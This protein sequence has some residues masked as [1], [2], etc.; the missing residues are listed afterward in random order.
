MDNSLWTLSFL[1]TNRKLI[2]RKRWSSRG[3]RSLV[4]PAM[5]NL[6]SI[7]GV[8]P[9]H[10]RP[11]QLHSD[12]RIRIRI[13]V[14][15]GRPR[16]RDGVRPSGGQGPPRGDRVRRLGTRFT[17]PHHIHPFLVIPLIVPLCVLDGILYPMLR[18]TQRLHHPRELPQC[19]DNTKYTNTVH[20]SDYGIMRRNLKGERE[21]RRKEV[22][23]VSAI[24][25]RERRPFVN[26]CEDFK[27]T[28]FAFRLT[29]YLL[30]T[31]WNRK[32]PNESRSLGDT[33]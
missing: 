10:G 12:D 21:L 6:F 25:L 19:K 30:W 26:D 9:G 23:R 5:L 13:V 16:A 3:L 8:C 28:S 18:Y 32:F 15:R 29:N 14:G 4:V 27:P 33:S 20:R 11:L 17:R 31:H 24:D 7:A 2:E 22:V 1:K